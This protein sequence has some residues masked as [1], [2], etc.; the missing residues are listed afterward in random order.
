MTLE[1][2]A[3]WFEENKT[4]LA[5]GVSSDVRKAELPHPLYFES[6]SG[7]RIRDVDGNEYIDYV[8]GQGPLLLGHNPRPVLEAVH[9]QLDR[10]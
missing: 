2:S 10:G 4:V 3:R 1:T 6:G 8:L 7:S 5:G 9:R